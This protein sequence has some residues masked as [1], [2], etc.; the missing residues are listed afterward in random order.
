MATATRPAAPTDLP[1]A[2]S[3]L[4]RFTNEAYAEM[5]R[6]G[7]ISK[8]QRVVLIEGLLVTRM[9]KGPSHVTTVENVVEQLKVIAPA[10]YRVRQEAPIVIAARTEAATARPNP[11][12]SSPAGPRPLSGCA[13]PSPARW[14]CWSR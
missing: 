12:W 5:G 11:T 7:L 2:D 6:L 8:E 3:R 4:H 14:R 10:G 1:V 13:I 9:N